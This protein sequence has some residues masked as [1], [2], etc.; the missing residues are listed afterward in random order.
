LSGT[1]SI[2]MKVTDSAG[3]DGTIATQEYVLDTAAPTVNAGDDMFTTVQISRTATATETGSGIASHLWTAD[4]VGVTFGSS[5]EL[6]T[7][8]TANVGAY[9]VTL[10]VTDIAGNIGTDEFELTYDTMYGFEYLGQS[11]HGFTAE[12]EEG[13]FS[14]HRFEYMDIWNP[15]LL[16][17]DFLNSAAGPTDERLV[18]TDVNT[19]YIYDA[20][21]DLDP[22]VTVDSSEYSERNFYDLI[23]PVTFIGFHLNKST[24]ALKSI[25]HI[26]KV[27]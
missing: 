26:P 2:R 6:T 17:E 4:P 1:S 16:V 9:T 23:S 7:T 15:D 20:T 18:S 21:N 10:T 3:N 19:I 14:E 24:A 12:V 25:R 22:W 11:G 27:V 5:N 8:I 13:W